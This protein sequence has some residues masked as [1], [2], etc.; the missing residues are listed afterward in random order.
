MVPAAVGV[1]T[2]EL[3]QVGLDVEDREPFR[4]HELENSFW[5]RFTRAAECANRDSELLVQLGRPS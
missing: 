3:L 5:S 4:A 2:P 1:R